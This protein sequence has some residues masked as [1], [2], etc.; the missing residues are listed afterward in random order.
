MTVPTY[1]AILLDPSLQ[2][3]RFRVCLPQSAALCTEILHFL[4]ID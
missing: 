2:F 3:V 1:G 4:Y